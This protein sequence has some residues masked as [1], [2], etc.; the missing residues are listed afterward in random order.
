MKCILQWRSGILFSIKK[1]RK[2]KKNVEKTNYEPEITKRQQISDGLDRCTIY[3][4]YEQ[5]LWIWQS[6]FRLQI[7]HDTRISSNH[8]FYSCPVLSF[9]CILVILS[10]SCYRSHSFRSL[11]LR[12]AIKIFWIDVLNDE[13]K[14]HDWSTAPTCGII[15]ALIYI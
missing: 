10:L 7:G 4:Q 3:Y 15:V 9:S 1:S 6:Y 13:F 14:T 8:S 11:Y 2:K 5:S 12:C